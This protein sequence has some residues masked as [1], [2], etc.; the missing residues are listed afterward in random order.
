MQVL[1]ATVRGAGRGLVGGARGGRA[2]RGG[3][4]GHAPTFTVAPSVDS[5][6]A[7]SILGNLGH[8][9]TSAK[10]VLIKD[11]TKVSDDN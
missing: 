6:I 1:D 4:R 9:K 11:K 8:Q 5:K 10:L 2:G 7:V 3:G